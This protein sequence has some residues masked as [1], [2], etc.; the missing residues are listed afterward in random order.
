MEK[1]FWITA[2]TNLLYNVISKFSFCS[3]SRCRCILTTHSSC[4]MNVHCACAK[5]LY[6]IPTMFC[7][8]RYSQWLDIYIASW[9]PLQCC[10]AWCMQMSHVLFTDKMHMWEFVTV[11]ISQKCVAL[12]ENYPLQLFYSGKEGKKM[13]KC[14]I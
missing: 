12:T 14:Y 9:E 4:T 11:L 6:S 3:V 2:S 5:H 7:I 8:Y 1:Y 10:Q 13:G